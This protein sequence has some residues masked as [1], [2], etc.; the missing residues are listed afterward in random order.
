MNDKPMVSIVTIVYNAAEYL[1]ETIQS[2]IN[3]TYDSVEYIVI[4][5]SST[6]GPLDVIKQYEG[7]INHWVS[8]EDRGIYDAMNK[9]INLANGEWINF[10]NSGDVFHDNDVLLNFYKESKKFQNVDFFYSDSIVKEGKKYI[11]NKEKRILIHQAIIYRIAMHKKIGSY[12]VV[13]NL[14]TAD[15]LFFMLSYNYNW[16]KLNFPISIH[17]THGVSSGL[18][19]FLQKNAIDLLF[20]FNGRIKTILFLSIHPLYN[21]IKTLFK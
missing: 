19:T 16:Q 15:Y 13:K 18:H 21:K 3:Q 17:D 8:E 9:G 5:G 6:D 2:V 12:V 20:G 14:T 1:E 10:M 4:D 7:E 11:C